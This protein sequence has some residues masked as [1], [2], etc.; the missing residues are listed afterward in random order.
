M[1]SLTDLALGL[2]TLYLVPR[3]PRDV[4]GAR[5]WRATFAW[6]AATALAG[7]VYH[8]FLVEL[9]RIGGITWAVMS[10]TVVVVMSFMLAATVVQVLGPSRAV[11]FWPLRLLGVAAYV[12]IAATGNPSIT[13]IMLCE[14]I[15]MACVIGLWV[16]AWRRRHPT[17][18]AMLVAIGAS[19]A[20]AMFRLVPGAAALLWLDPDSA[21]H[22]GQ[23]VGI[24]LL[25]RAVASSEPL[26][27][28]AADVAPG[29]A[30]ATD[31]T[32]PAAVEGREPAGPVA[33]PG[34]RRRSR[35]ADGPHGRST[36]GR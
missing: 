23:I 2:V 3:L 11:W 13:A 34:S 7:A 26:P 8:G 10:T 20:A 27:G 15:T 14:S 35:Q 22:L 9:P 32:P 12:I 18:P 31:G 5:Y 21:Y 36:P 28:T 1:A 29:P 30:R 19:I 4:D 17:A 25:F 24:V 16:W 6:A 33:S